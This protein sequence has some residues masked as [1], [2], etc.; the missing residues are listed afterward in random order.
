LRGKYV[1]A[2]KVSQNPLIVY[3]VNSRELNRRI[4]RYGMRDYK[5]LTLYLR[6]GHKCEA[7]LSPDDVRKFTDWLREQN[8][9][10]RWGAYDDLDSTPNAKA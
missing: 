3:W 5:I 7:Y 1:A 2:L 6:D 8:P 9:S 10:V 4:A